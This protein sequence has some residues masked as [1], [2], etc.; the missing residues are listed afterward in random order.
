MRSRSARRATVVLY[1]LVRGTSGFLII[2]GSW[3]RAPPA[4]PARS[5][6]LTRRFTP[7]RA[8]GKTAGVDRLT[9]DT[10]WE[11]RAR[12]ASRRRRRLR[13]P[14][15]TRL[16]R[17]PGSNLRRWRRWCPR[18]PPPWG[19]VQSSL[20]HR[21]ACLEDA[22]RSHSCQRSRATQLD[23]TSRPTRRSGSPSDVRSRASH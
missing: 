22:P 20:S 23:L 13:P 16:R 19:Q 14:T 15:S 21:Q 7:R 6:S 2:P 12:L 3:V 8:T 17:C 4:P 18:A 11:P 5:C 1:V 10:W 9:G